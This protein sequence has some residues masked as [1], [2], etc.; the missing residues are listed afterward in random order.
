M[1]EIGDVETLEQGLVL[2]ETVGVHVRDLSARSR[3]EYCNDVADLINFLQSQGTSRL[4]QV[5]LQDLENYQAEMV[6]RDYAASTRRRKT[7]AIK[8]FFT[9][10]YERGM[11][12]TDVTAQLTPPKREKKEPRYLSERE[13]ERLLRAC[14]HKPRDAAII[15]VFLQ[16]GMRLSEL[17]GLTLAD[18]ELPGRVA[19]DESTLGR[20]R[21][22]RKGGKVAYIPINYKACRA[23]K[24]WLK[25]RPDVEHNALFVSKFRN[26][27]SKRAIQYTI[28]KYLDEA[29]IEDASVHTLRHTWA[30]HHVRQGTNIKTVQAI[31]GHESLETT[32]VYISLAKKEMER[33]LQEHAL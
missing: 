9:F 25:V 13:Y 2:F 28:K 33:E 20:A 22:K 3:E 30:T 6:R 24:T 5:G 31:L 16:T 4:V 17:A 14:S 26:P 29:G 8:S 18:I 32:N 7:Y 12:G 1:P 11:I 27:M 21:V 23:L 15:E 10:L 19:K